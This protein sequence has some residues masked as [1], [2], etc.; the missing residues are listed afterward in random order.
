MLTMYKKSH[1]FLA[2][3]VWFVWLLSKY[4]NSFFL[5]FLR[6]ALLISNLSPEAYYRLTP[7]CETIGVIRK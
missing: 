4:K 5:F 7:I 2:V 6:F 1:T 3:F